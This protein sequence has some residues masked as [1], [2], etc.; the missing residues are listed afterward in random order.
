MQRPRTNRHQIRELRRWLVDAVLDFTYRLIRLEDR[1]DRLDKRLDDH[2][3]HV[4]P[5]RQEPY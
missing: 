2:E 1:L 4:Y 3:N 5:P